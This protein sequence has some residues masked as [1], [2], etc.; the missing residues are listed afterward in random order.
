MNATQKRTVIRPLPDPERMIHAIGHPMRWRLLREL[1]S[2]DVRTIGELAAA[3]GC[4]YDNALRHLGILR[5]AGLVV[6]ERGKLFN[7]PRQFLPTP[8]RPHVD[9]G[10][11]LLRM[12]A[13]EESAGK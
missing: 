7:I 1:S 11:C 13:G 8:D 10:H 3:A 6:Q 12:D 4:Q 2:G 9:Y 5:Q